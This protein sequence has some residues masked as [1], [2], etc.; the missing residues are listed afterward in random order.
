[1]RLPTYDPSLELLASSISS[2]EFDFFLRKP[3]F[4]LRDFGAPSPD[5]FFNMNAS[6]SRARQPATV[7]ALSA[8]A[9]GS[10]VASV[11]TGSTT[12]FDAAA[13]STLGAVYAA[14]RTSGDSDA[15]NGAGRAATGPG[16]DM[17]AGDFLSA[18]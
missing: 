18:S 16:T 15:V 11:A 4:Q 14:V 7:T 3:D 5:T 6:L 12:G 9:A 10:G 8:A 2:I 1:M 17:A 13:V